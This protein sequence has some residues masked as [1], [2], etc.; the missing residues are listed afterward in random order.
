MSS[1]PLVVLILGFLMILNGHPDTYYPYYDPYSNVKCSDLVNITFYSY[2]IHVLFWGA[3]N[4]S[5]N[6]AF[7]LISKFQNEFN[8]PNYNISNC[9]DINTTTGNSPEMCI[10]WYDTLPYS[11]FLTAN[12][13]IFVPEYNFTKTVQWMM[14][15]H[16]NLDVMIHPNSGCEIY[17]H[18]DWPLWIGKKSEIDY[19][20]L[21]YDAPGYN[22][23][24]CIDKANTLMFQNNYNNY[25]DMCGLT[26][27]NDTMTY[28]TPNMNTNNQYCT[29][30]CQ[31]WIDKLIQFGHD[32]PGNCDYY[33]NN[34][35]DTNKEYICTVNWNSFDALKT[36]SLKMC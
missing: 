34:I 31:T 30:L 6:D 14:L 23:Y 9:N 28:N 2:H 12:W 3:N 8:I 21:N 13:C 18:R 17:D 16:G 4:Q 33:Q 7:Q 5:T 35:N 32:C 19:R 27:N 25:N 20:A 22:Y 10:S 29:T 36:W 24:T 11:P 15:N 26:I 1:K